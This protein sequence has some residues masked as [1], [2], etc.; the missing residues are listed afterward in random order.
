MSDWRKSLVQRR[1]RGQSWARVTSLFSSHSNQDY[2]DMEARFLCPYTY[3][4]TM[5]PGRPSLS[6]FVSS[7]IRWLVIGGYALRTHAPLLPTQGPVYRI[8][9]PP[10]GSRARGEGLPRGQSSP[11]LP[12]IHGSNGSRH[13]SLDNLKIALPAGFLFQRV[14]AHAHQ[15]SHTS[16][17]L[18]G[19]GRFKP[20]PWSVF[21]PSQLRPFLNHRSYPSKLA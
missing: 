9:L 18:T 20:E 3:Q 15:L 17:R 21:T 12:S 6:R 16:G 7:T 8:S 5:I 10:T 11:P 14:S 1:R 4:W 13:A 2:G 19:P